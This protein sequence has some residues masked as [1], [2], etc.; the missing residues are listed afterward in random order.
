MK[1]RVWHAQNPPNYMHFY[2][3]N[4]PK[5]GL[6]LIDELAE[7]DLGNPSVEVNAFGLEY[8]DEVDKEWYEWRDPEWDYDITELKRAIEDGKIED[9][10]EL[11]TC[12]HL[13]P[14]KVGG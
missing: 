13:E 9:G 5:E 11:W 7:E 8:Y 12:N 3:V 14:K 2:R 10:E 1:L 4:S 6:S